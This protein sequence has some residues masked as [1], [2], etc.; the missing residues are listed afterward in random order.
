[1]GPGGRGSHVAGEQRCNASDHHSPVEIHALLGELPVTVV[2]VLEGLVLHDLHPFPSVALFVAVLADHVQL[3]DFVLQN[4]ETEVSPPLALENT[5]PPS[6]APQTSNIS[7]FCSKESRHVG[8]MFLFLWS[9]EDSE[10]V[11]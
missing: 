1:M 8:L 6:T 11:S 7:T 9:E 10:P 2:R 5:L 4:T 3:S